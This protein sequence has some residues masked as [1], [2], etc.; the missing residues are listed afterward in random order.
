MEPVSETVELGDASIAT[1]RWGH[2][3]PSIVMLHDGLGSAAQWRGVPAA[4]AKRTGRTVLAYDRPGHGGSTPT[5]TGPWPDDWLVEQAELL[6]ALLAHFGTERP[7][8]VGHSDG[9]TIALIR[10]TTDASI[11]GIVAIAAHTFVERVAIDF[12]RELRTDPAPVIAGLARHHAE[13]VALWEAWSGAWT[14]D[15]L[16]GFDIRPQLGSIDVPVL[17]VQGDGDEYATMAQLTDTAAAIG[18]NAM[19]KLL[20]DTRHLPHHTT[21]DVVVELVHDF[22]AT[23]LDDSD[24]QGLDARPRAGR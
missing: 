8:L 1:T 21:P 12:I 4:I 20:P 7:V 24:D 3:A 14:S 9:G 17:V 2:D 19:P 18:D 5:P 6:G 11:A 22:V 15:R 16:A 13:P 10:A 23:H